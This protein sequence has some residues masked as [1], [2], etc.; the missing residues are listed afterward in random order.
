[1][2]NNTVWE[3]V[4][5]WFPQSLADFFLVVRRSRMELG[6]IPATKPVFFPSFFFRCWLIYVLFFTAIYSTKL[7]QQP[8]HALTD[9]LCPTVLWSCT[10]WVRGLGLT[11]I[12]ET[13]WKSVVCEVRICSLRNENPL[14]GERRLLI[15]REQRR[16]RRQQETA[17]QKEHRLAQRRQRRQQETEEQ[18]IGIRGIMIVLH[19][20]KP[21]FLSLLVSSPIHRSKSAKIQL[22]ITA[23]G[24]TIFRR[25]ALGHICSLFFSFSKSGRRNNEQGLEH[26]LQS[27]A[28]HYRPR[29]ISAPHSKPSHFNPPPL[30]FRPLT[31]S[32]PPHLA[33]IPI[34][35]PPIL[36]PPF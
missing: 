6:S 1:M 34:P 23:R 31:I 8:V 20:R 14:E 10:W 18:E 7:K 12:C 27:Q 2:S 32:G 17:E 29:T 5:I 30:H 35:N 28:P 16:R 4:I 22:C 15:Q 24:I 11:V 36:H 3:Y 13:K 26:S 33:P 25:T 9:C 21:R 19:C